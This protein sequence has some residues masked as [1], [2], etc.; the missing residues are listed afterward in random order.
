V[1]GFAGETSPHGFVYADGVMTDLNDLID[2]GSGLT[3]YS[4]YAINNAGW[5]TADAQD[6]QGHRHSVVLTPD[7]GGAPRGAD[8][9]VFLLQAP[10]REATPI[11]GI[12]G[13]PPVSV[14]PKGAPQEAVAPLPAGVTLPQTTDAVFAHSHRPPT[15][16]GEGAWE[17]EGLGLGL[18]TV[19]PV[20]APSVLRTA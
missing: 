12:T 15:P 3:I 1:V 13:Q 20:E 19:P 11:G 2:P 17:I 6:V 10:V 16:A 18:S 7:G 5:I 4:A 9:G 8:P 14:L